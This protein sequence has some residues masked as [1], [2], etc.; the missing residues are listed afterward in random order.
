MRKQLVIIGAGGF[1]REVYAWAQQTFDFNEEW[2]FKGFLDDNSSILDNFNYNAKII[3]N[4]NEYMPKAED[5][6][7]CAIGN[8]TIKKR[9]TK[10]ILD[11][12]GIFTNL[13][14]PTVIVGNNVSM[15]N[16]IILCPRV[17]LT[18]D[19]IVGN[20]VSLN[21]DT[22]IGHDVTVGNYCQVSS[23]C[24]VTGGVTL[25]EGVFMGSHASILPKGVVGDFAKVG[26]G[27]IVISK[28]K[29]YSTVFGVP[30]KPITI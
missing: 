16:G 25:G 18:C 9:L 4:V 10:I 26:A 6:F 28:V 12:G 8:P 7:L 19:I 24:D 20:F 2:E 29:E 15:G 17:I 23:F 11:K 14:H 1:G 27:S 22:S 13:I 30:A 3:S 5:R 21:F